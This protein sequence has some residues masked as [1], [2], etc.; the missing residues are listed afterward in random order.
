MSTNH[1]MCTLFEFLF[2]LSK[3]NMTLIRQLKFDSLIRYLKLIQ[4]FLV[5]MVWL[6]FHKLY[7][8]EIQWNIYGWNGIC[9][10]F[11]SWWYRV[12]KWMNSCLMKWQLLKL[13][14]RNRR[15]NF[16]MMSTYTK[17]FKYRYYCHKIIPFHSKSSS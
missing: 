4:L 14:D 15:V 3:R 2:K 8:W 10:R 7:H 11:A 5:I 6:C 9:L 17:I 16:I 1:N 13:Y 12:G